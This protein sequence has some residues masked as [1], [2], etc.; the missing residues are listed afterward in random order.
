M[1][2]SNVQAIGVRLNHLNS[3]A[4]S[5]KLERIDWGEQNEANL[6]KI[7]W[8]STFT[9]LILLHQSRDNARRSSLGSSASYPEQLWQIVH[10]QFA[11]NSGHLRG[12]NRLFK[13]NQM[14]L[15][16]RLQLIASR[17]EA[18]GC[19]RATE[20]GPTVSAWNSVTLR[21][22]SVFGILYF[23]CCLNV[24]VDVLNFSARNSLVLLFNFF[25]PHV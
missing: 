1:I 3:A 20:I 8:L 14:I 19:F 16:L 18:L 24:L 11:F 6:V 10:L 17:S 22:E 23:S 13:L 4:S 21:T 25:T 9:R 12:D 2:S 7:Y 15:R 5:F